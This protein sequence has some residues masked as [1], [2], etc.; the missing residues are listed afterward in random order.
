MFVRLVKKNN[1][2]VSV[3]IVEN[4]RIG[5]KI[6][7]K[8]ICSIAQCHKDDHKKI[9]TFKRFGEELMYNVV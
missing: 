4:E 1:D 6:K 8:T 5:D 9:E 7:Q 2:R 3:R